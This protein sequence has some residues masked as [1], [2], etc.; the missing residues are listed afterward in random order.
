MVL[1]ALRGAVGFL[2]R[3]PVGTDGDG[4]DA[5]AASP[6]AFPAVGYVVGGGV[7]AIVGV[8]AVLDLPP[9]TIAVAAGATIYLL[10]GIAHLDGVAD[11]GDAAAV[12]GE[13]EARVAVLKDSRVGVGAAGAV[14]GT[15][16]ATALG[17]FAAAGLPVVAAVG[18]VVASEVGAKL[19]MAGVACL[20]TAAHEGMGSRFTGPNGAGDLV[21][22]ILLAL[23]V[24]VGPLVLAGPPLRL[25]GGVVVA[26]LGGLAGAVAGGWAVAAWATRALAGVNGD[27]FGATN[28]VA[29]AVGLHAGVVL[30]TLS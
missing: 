5:F 14:A 7:A 16:L 21:A 23:P 19:A 9:A 22:P 28:E 18:L 25:G 8:G 20:G 3:L 6:S 24:V 2:T 17:L 12:H 26:A 11:L 1:T 4:W 10:A 30:W 27:V 13:P 29:R 15:L